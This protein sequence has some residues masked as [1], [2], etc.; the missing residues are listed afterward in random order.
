MP[1]SCTSHFRTG[2]RRRLARRHTTARVGN[3]RVQPSG[4]ESHTHTHTHSQWGPNSL[5]SLNSETG[6][7]RARATG[8]NDICISRSPTLRRIGFEPSERARR[9]CEKTLNA[10]KQIEPNWGPCHDYGPRWA[11]IDAICHHAP[12]REGGQIFKLRRHFG[13][14]GRV[15][16]SASPAH[17]P[18]GARPSP[19]SQVG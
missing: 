12:A 7:Q 16:A 2:T 6:A 19:L 13:K 1:N 18:T 3:D 11:R 15:E 17:G 10:A 14:R 9:P 4:S 8:E 5:A